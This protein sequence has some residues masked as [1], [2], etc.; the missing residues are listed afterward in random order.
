MRFQPATVI[1]LLISSAVV[2]ASPAPPSP[3]PSTEASPTIKPEDV[4]RLQ[5]EIRA[6]VRD[7]DKAKGGEMQT[8]SAVGCAALGVALAACAVSTSGFGAIACAGASATIVFITLIF[9]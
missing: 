4:P 3:Q 8:E 7:D 2:S 1:T 5:E 9:L 6:L